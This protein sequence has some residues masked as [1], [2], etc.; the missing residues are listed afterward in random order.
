MTVIGWRAQPLA[1]TYYTN[2]TVLRTNL[3]GPALG[4]GGLGGGRRI[5]VSAMLAGWLS[6]RLRRTEENLWGLLPVTLV[7]QAG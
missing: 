2:A 4:T 3:R 7:N 6:P 5:G 1:L